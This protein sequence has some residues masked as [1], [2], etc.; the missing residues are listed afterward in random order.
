MICLPVSP[1]IRLL[2]TSHVS[3]SHLS[4]LYCPRGSRYNC[5]VSRTFYNST[6]LFPGLE[7]FLCIWLARE[8]ECQQPRFLF[9]NLT[10][11]TKRLSFPRAPVESPGTVLQTQVCSL[12]IAVGR[13]LGDCHGQSWAVCPQLRPQGVGSAHAN[14]VE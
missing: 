9:T 14:R 7:L 3:L 6:N 8:T 13:A 10:P 5:S 2:N 4:K 1:L 12:A 11:P